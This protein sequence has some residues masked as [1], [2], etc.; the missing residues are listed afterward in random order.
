MFQTLSC[1]DPKNRTPSW[2]NTKGWKLCGTVYCGY[3]YLHR[4]ITKG[5]FHY[6]RTVLSI[7][8]TFNVDQLPRHQ[9]Y[10]LFIW[11]GFCCSFALEIRGEGCWMPKCHEKWS[12]KQ[13]G[14]VRS[15]FSKRGMNFCPFPLHADP[16][17][18]VLIPAN[19]AAKH[20][21]RTLFS[22]NALQEQ[23]WIQILLTPCTIIYH[24]C[25]FRAGWLLCSQYLQR[26]KTAWDLWGLSQPLSWCSFLSGLNEP[27]SPV[28]TLWQ[29]SQSF[30]CCLSCSL[31]NWVDTTNHLDAC[32]TIAEVVWCSSLFF[33]ESPPLLCSR[34]NLLLQHWP[35]PSAKADPWKLFLLHQTS[36]LE[37]LDERCWRL[38]PLPFEIYSSVTACLS[39]TQWSSHHADMHREGTQTDNFEASPGHT[40]SLFTV[41]TSEL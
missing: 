27:P 25:D 16:L 1:G 7:I 40:K 22:S 5:T 24:H 18:R 38:N 3:A 17:G 13:H 35:V 31:K 6:L 8:R 23:A 4:T 34:C 12:A 10:Q 2:S 33:C 15:R 21:W 20:S 32:R 28:P 37:N 41:N 9:L 29:I 30:V 19:G 26:C 11:A 14:T 39:T 36:V